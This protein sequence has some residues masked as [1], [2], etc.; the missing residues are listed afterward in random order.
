MRRAPT[1]RRRFRFEVRGLESLP[2]QGGALAVANHSGGKLTP[3][4]LIF[5]AAYYGRFGYDRSSFS[6][7]IPVASDVSRTRANGSSMCVGSDT[8]MPPSSLPLIRCGDLSLLAG[9]EATMG[10]SAE[11]S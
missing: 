6:L 1:A 10:R 5:A 2:A 11:P 8:A 4:V 3:D 7:A 9:T